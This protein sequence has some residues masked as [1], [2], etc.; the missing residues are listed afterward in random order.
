MQRVFITLVLLAAVHCLS[1]KQLRLKDIVE[2][3]IFSPKG[4][5]QMHSVGDGYFT[6]MSADGQ[7]LLKKYADRDYTETLLDSLVI[8][9]KRVAISSYELS[10][11]RKKALIA[12]EKERIYRHS[13]KADYF[14]VNLKDKKVATVKIKGKVQQATFSPDGGKIAYVRENN[15]YY[16]DLHSGKEFQI[17]KDGAFRKIINGL[18]DWVYE[19]EFAFSRAFEWSPNSKQLAYLKFDEEDV[20]VYTLYYYDKD[21]S[22]PRPYSYK[23]PKAGETN[24]TVGVWLYDMETKKNREISVDKNKEQYIPRVRWAKTDDKLLVLRLNRHQN[25][26]DYLM[27]DTQTGTVDNVYTQKNSRFVDSSNFD[28]I[29]FLDSDSFSLLAESSGFN[30][31]YRFNYITKK[32]SPWLVK[33]WDITA[34]YG[35]DN[36]GNAYCQVASRFPYNREVLKVAS[37][38]TFSIL[39]EQ[40]GW[41]TAKFDKDFRFAIQIHSTSTQPPVYTVRDLKKG[42]SYILEDNKKL[43]NDLQKYHLPK[44]EFVNLPSAISSIALSAWCL[45]PLDFQP[46]KKYPV[47]IT[48]YS[49]PNS[50]RVRNSFSLGWEV[51]LAQAGYIV[52]C[53]DTRGTAARGEDFRKCTYMQLGKLESDDLIAVGKYLQTLPYVEKD[54]ITLWGWSYGGFMSTLCLMKGKGVFNASISVAPVTHWKFYDSV[55]TERYMRTPQENAKGYDENSPLEN[56]DLLK[57]SK[58]KLLLVH[59]TADDNVHIQNTYTLTAKLVAMNFPFQEQIYTDKNH[60]IYGKNTRLH[61]YEKFVKFLNEV[62]R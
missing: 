36:E 23:Y 25:K 12:T 42:K 18:P 44:K 6:T 22:Y 49:G 20:R 33:T 61:L 4:I 29:T 27:V 10:F 46:D 2:D 15:L 51:Y 38:G 35:V 48:Q 34:F 39:S 32:L 8:N 56:T 43:K 54:K 16:L 24:A 45:K 28:A 55:Y 19:E 40:K 13:F 7:I 59:G 60:S 26:L 3:K 57:D 5:E 50:Q 62:N 14:I 52:Y 58:A 11:D 9:G 53:V 21:K 47:L 17:T 1:A 41:N 30:S 37:N 31:L